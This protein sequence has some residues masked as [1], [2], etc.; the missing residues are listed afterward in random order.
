MNVEFDPGTDE[1]FS[2]NYA[3]DSD[4]MATET[5]EREFET[6]WAEKLVAQRGRQAASAKLPVLPS[7]HTCHWL[8]KTMVMDANGRILPCCAAPHSAGELVFS[9]L[10]HTRPDDCFNSELYQEARLFFAEQGRLPARARA[11]WRDSRPVLRGLQ[12]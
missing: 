12:I 9:T 11:E 5:I 3:V 8:Y 1:K 2:E 10:T 7:E 4:E 6:P